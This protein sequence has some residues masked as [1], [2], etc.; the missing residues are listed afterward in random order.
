MQHFIA[1]GQHFHIQHC[2]LLA[3]QVRNTITQSG[4]L[5]RRKIWRS[6]KMPRRKRLEAGAGADVWAVGDGVIAV[7]I[8]ARQVQVTVA[9]LDAKRT[10][11]GPA[12]ADVGF[13]V[14]INAAGERTE[15]SNNRR[16]GGSC[17]RFSTAG[18]RRPRPHNLHR[19]VSDWCKYLYHPRSR[20]TAPAE[21]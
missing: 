9:G 10:H 19:P 6:K 16:T 12:G 3:C 13:L 4:M 15:S 5:T 11:N 21:Y 20:G 8:F 14:A 17:R 1:G 7:A 2:S 18:R